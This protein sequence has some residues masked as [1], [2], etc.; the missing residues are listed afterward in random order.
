MPASRLN[1]S[2]V[3]LLTPENDPSSIPPDSLSALD[4]AIAAYIAR[5]AA[6]VGRFRLPEPW[7]PHLRDAA[8][9]CLGRLK[10]EGNIAAGSVAIYPDGRTLITGDA[11]G[12]IGCWN[13]ADGGKLRPFHGQHSAQIQDIAVS[14]NGPLVGD[15]LQR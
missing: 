8:G 9:K 5:Q 14:P 7:V 2:P 3:E 15:R 4:P 6:T 1:P 12:S 13:L 11:F 10:G